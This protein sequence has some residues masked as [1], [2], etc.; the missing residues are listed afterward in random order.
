MCHLL[1]MKKRTDPLPRLIDRMRMNWPEVSNAQT[2]VTVAVQRLARLL[3]ENAAKTLMPLGL[4]TT[5]MEVLAAMHS[6]KVPFKLAP[7][8]LYDAILISSG[9]L[10]KVLKSL[11]ARGLIDRPA[12]DSDGRSKPIQLTEAG[13]ILAEQAML[14]VQ[15]ADAPVFS[16]LSEI[17]DLELLER[18]LNELTRQ[19]ER[20]RPPGNTCS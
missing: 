12:S 16:T 2:F 15:A 7:S 13:K 10:T 19:A 17:S 8:E 6:H 9:G 4:T 1:A 5:E 18:L 20:M 11:S 3:E 14:A